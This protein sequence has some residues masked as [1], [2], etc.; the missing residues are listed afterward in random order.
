MSGF[1][2][3]NGHCQLPGHVPVDGR[4]DLWGCVPISCEWTAVSAGSG[5]WR[6]LDFQ[7]LQVREKCSVPPA[8][9]KAVIFISLR[10]GVT[11]RL[12]SGRRGTQLRAEDLLACLLSVVLAPAA[13]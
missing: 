3:R 6:R 8:G 12:R 11:G 4:S 7:S 1:S 13:S 9:D 5:Q 2:V 10:S